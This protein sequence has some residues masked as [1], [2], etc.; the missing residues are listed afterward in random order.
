MEETKCWLADNVSQRSGAKFKN[1]R[2]NKKTGD[3]ELQVTEPSE[4]EDFSEA[5]SAPR[6]Y[7]QQP[8]SRHIPPAV[9]IVTQGQTINQNY[10]PT[11]HSA[12]SINTNMVI[13]SIHI[14]Q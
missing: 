13:T 10:R 9:R 14:N 7:V 1:T 12:T 6:L 3:R 2:G 5:P 8:W 4:E 11:E